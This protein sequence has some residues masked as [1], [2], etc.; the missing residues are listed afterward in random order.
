MQYDVV[1]LAV[2]AELPLRVEG[3][4]FDLV[5]AGGDGD[6]GVGEEGLQMRNFKIRHP[7]ALD[8]PLHYALLQFHVALVASYFVERVIVLEPGGGWPVDEEEVDVLHSQIMQR[9]TEGT[10]SF[11][12]PLI[13]GG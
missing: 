5:D 1:L 2:S 11:V 7:Q 12:C 9:L 6:G 4:A 13:L 8:L 10:I 3:V